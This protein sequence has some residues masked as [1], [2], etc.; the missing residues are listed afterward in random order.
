MSETDKELKAFFE[1]GI[2]S[3]KHNDYDDSMNCNESFH[4]E[5]RNEDIAHCIKA[6][7]FNFVANSSLYKSKMKIF[8][9][10]LVLVSLLV[11]TE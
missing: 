11:V 3:R 7:T 4:L 5:F 2:L 10:I 1:A 6:K 9:F 8:S